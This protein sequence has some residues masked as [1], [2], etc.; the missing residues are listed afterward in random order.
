MFEDLNVDEAPLEQA[1][2]DRADREAEVAKTRKIQDVSE[3][4]IF[5]IPKQDPKTGLRNLPSDIED[6]LNVR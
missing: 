1:I 3:M 5:N 4:D 6:D 2:Q